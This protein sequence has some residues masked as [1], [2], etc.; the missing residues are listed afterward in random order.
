MGD[1]SLL[2]SVVLDKKGFS[3]KCQN[4]NMDF[5]KDG[6]KVLRAKRNGNIFVPYLDVV[7]YRPTE[8][9]FVAKTTSLELWHQR[10]GHV[11]DKVIKA[12]EQNGLVTGLVVGTLKRKS[13]DGCFLGKVSEDPPY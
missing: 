10:L 12:M 9:A 6:K 2:S 7:S 1:V 4:G 5:W 8:T 3:L 11:S 13:C